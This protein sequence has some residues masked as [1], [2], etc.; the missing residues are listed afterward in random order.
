[1][2]N[3]LRSH[4]KSVVVWVLLAMLILGLG[5]FGMTNFGGRTTAIG[6]VGET[7]I[8]VNDYARALRDEMN[9]ATAQIGRPFTI[10]EAKQMGLDRQVQGR[11]FGQAAVSE[12]AR[13][14]GLSVGDAEIHRQITQA[15]AFQGLDGKFDRET[16][17]LALRQEGYTEVQF[18]E[19]LRADAARSIMQAAVAAGVKAP[20]GVVDA[21]ATYL[22]EERTISYAEV[23]GADLTE[24]VPEPTEETLRAWHQDH[25]ADFTRP[26]LREISYVWLSPEMM[27]E[28]VTLDE[29]ALQAAY[30]A[31]KDDYVQPEKR[32]VEKLVYP[33]TEEAAAAKA[34]LD[35]GE[36]SFADLAAERGLTLDDIDLGEPAQEDLGP[37]GEAVFALETPGVVG[38]IDTDLGP[39]LFSM[40]AIIAEQN[41]TFEEARE[42]LSAEARMDRAR[43]LIDEASADLEDRLAGGATLEQMADETDMELGHI[44]L[45]PDTDEGLAGYEA[46]RDAAAT[47]TAEDFPELGSLDDGG[48]FALRLDGITP[49]ALF[50]FEEVRDRVI[51]SWRAAETAKLKRARAETIKAAVEGGATLGSQG[52]LVNTVGALQRSSFIENVPATLVDTAFDTAPGKAAI[53][54]GGG[55]VVVVKVEGVHA[56]DSAAEEVAQIREL[57]EVR[58]AQSVANDLLD[59]YARAAQAEAGM[60]IDSTAINAVQAQMQ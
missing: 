58:L 59:F 5:G 22:T 49:A 47:V 2:S 12:A 28:K 17:R 6:S 1:M 20:A 16:Y 37:A 43:R 3:K 46:F 55:K 29:A 24:T 11:M 35:A 57:L 44:S 7:E 39:A 42:E 52:V 18:E 38:P 36:V 13:K 30:E 9:A 45:A 54:E 15:R 14:I 31:R 27:A 19:R 53:V 56:A 10:A 21:Y 23:T 40:N 50:P 34:R 41:T 26:E 33:T 4:G 51:D 32:M 8:P 48:V 25:A 60:T